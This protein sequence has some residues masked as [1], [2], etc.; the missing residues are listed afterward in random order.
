MMLYRGYTVARMGI[1]APTASVLL[2]AVPVLYDLVQG[3]L[4]EHGG[5][6]R[7]GPRSRGVGADHL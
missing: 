1:V 4:A 3:Q 7:H 2:A 6:L 5:R